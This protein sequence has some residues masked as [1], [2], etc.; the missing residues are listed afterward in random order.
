M[1]ISQDNRSLFPKSSLDSF[2]S[3][4]PGCEIPADFRSRSCVCVCARAH[5]RVCV[6]EVPKKRSVSL[7]V[8][9]VAIRRVTVVVVTM[10]DVRALIA[11]SHHS[12]LGGFFALSGRHLKGSPYSHTPLALK[13]QLAHFAIFLFLAVFPAF[14]LVL[15]LQ[16]NDDKFIERQATFSDPRL[17]TS[18]PQTAVDSCR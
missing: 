3:F 14:L 17:V 5:A 16:L 1:V 15:S 18:R 9:F 11:A 4:L 7:A 13:G 2:C 8:S 6:C 10:S 12:S